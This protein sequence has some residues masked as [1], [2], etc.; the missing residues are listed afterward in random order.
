M[1]GGLVVGLCSRPP[2]EQL[3][4]NAAVTALRAQDELATRVLEDAVLPERRLAYGDWG[5]HFKRDGKVFGTI[6]VP[7][8]FTAAAAAADPSVMVHYVTVL[9]LVLNP[10]GRAILEAHGIGFEFFQGKAA[11]SIIA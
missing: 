2:V 5:V 6:R 4:I 9:G 7:K 8:D 11:P 1:V 3:V 10:V